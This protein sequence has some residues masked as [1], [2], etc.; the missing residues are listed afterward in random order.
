[1]GIDP[2]LARTGIGV[3]ECR[4]RRMRA[5]YFGVVRSSASAAMADRLATIHRGVREVLDRYT[6]TG[7]GI[8][9]VFVGHNAR[10]ALLLGHARAAALLAL[11]LD[12][13]GVGEYSPAEVKRAVGAGGRG[14][15]EQVSS[16]VRMLVSGIE[17]A[18]A[19]DA[20]DALAVAVCHINRVGQ[21]R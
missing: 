1:M 4:A 5:L 15:K 17:G 16:L 10:S 18:I 21:A 19:E 20:S 2:G 14:S 8:E 13:I 11:A 9:R 7:A 6:V 3:V 12:G